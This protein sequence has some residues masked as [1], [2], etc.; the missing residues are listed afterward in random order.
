M[1]GTRVLY[2]FGQLLLTTRRYKQHDL[3]ED[4][5]PAA[6]GGEP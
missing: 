5:R 6:R 4:V 1:A 3:A 2:A